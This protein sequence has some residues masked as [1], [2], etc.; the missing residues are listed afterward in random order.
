MKLLTRSS[1]PENST[2]LQ[3][4]NHGNRPAAVAG[5]V[6]TGVPV[7]AGNNARGEAG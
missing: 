7:Y 5:V 4:V 6:D 1:L 3:G 2:A